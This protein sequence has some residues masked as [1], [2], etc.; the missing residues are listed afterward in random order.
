MR[1]DPDSEPPVS[2][3]VAS[4]LAPYRSELLALVRKK[5]GPGLLRF[6]GP[7]DL[8]Q[9][10]LHRALAAQ[11]GYTDRGEEA[12]RAW[13]FTL[14]RRHLISRRRYWF[15]LRRRSGHLVRLT[16][17]DSGTATPFQIPASQ[18]GPS[19]YA[20]RREQ[21][22]LV[23]QALSYLLPRDQDLVLLTGEGLSV[24]EIA[25]RLD[26]T[27]DAASRARS[28]AFERLKKLYLLVSTRRKPSSG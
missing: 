12:F 2:G 26:T 19:T 15:A 18:T 17:A 14:A 6:E 13:L 5:A 28:R 21:L 27:Y 1:P 24:Q 22:V 20:S 11:D 25:D 3:E 16:L 8:V 7:E 10:V 9:G 4:R 23:N